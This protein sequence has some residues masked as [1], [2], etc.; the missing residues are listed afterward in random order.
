VTSSDVAPRSRAE[1]T[2]EGEGCAAW[3][4]PGDN[5]ACV[6][7]GAGM[8][9]TKE[10]GT[11]LFARLFQEAGYTVL[12]FD[13]RRFGESEGTPRQ[14]V[15]LRDEHRDWEA[16]LDYAT[17]LPN[18]DSGRIAAWGFSSA[19]GHVLQL[20][21]SREVGLA[22]GIALSPLVDGR[23]ALRHAAPH[24]SPRAAGALLF[25][26]LADALRVA[27]G[28]TD[29]HLVPL[30][31]TRGTVAVLTTPDAVADAELALDPQGEYE[32]WRREVAARS[33]LGL[34][35]FR[36]I[37]WASEVNCPLL[38]VVADDDMSVPPRRGRDVA[39]LAPGAELYEVT[40]GHYAPLL[41]TP[42]DV[43]HSVAQAQLDFLRRNLATDS[44]P[45]SRP[46]G[47]PQP[48][49]GRHGYGSARA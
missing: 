2:S 32:S 13:Y 35:G 21:S 5:G 30:V 46:R 7:M 39:R 41:T 4:Y 38:V 24:Q 26:A 23:A 22:A 19:G 49:A 44:A 11:D 42:S 34:P 9:V 12:A 40:G 16:A 6:V 8:G 48:G 17:S 18:V 47:R 1:F 3:H 20:A 45:T 33:V 43:H 14:L 10:P 25:R 31:G 36:P 29:R 15:R 28:G 37:R 27:M